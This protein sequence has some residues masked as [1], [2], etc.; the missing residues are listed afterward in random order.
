MSAVS[1]SDQ[2]KALAMVGRGSAKRDLLLL[3]LIRQTS[4]TDGQRR[5]IEKMWAERQRQKQS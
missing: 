5:L 3:S 4:L 1:I 2:A